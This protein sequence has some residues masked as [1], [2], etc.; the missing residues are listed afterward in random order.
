MF[1]K[2]RKARLFLVGE[3]REGSLEKVAFELGLE[4][5]EDYFPFHEG[6]I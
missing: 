3:I 6:N 4:D 1:R 5:S 2:S